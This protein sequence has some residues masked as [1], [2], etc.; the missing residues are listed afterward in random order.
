V[1]IDLDFIVRQSL[2]V[3]DIILEETGKRIDSVGH[4]D[5]REILGR[6]V[7]SNLDMLD[8]L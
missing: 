4:G 2:D 5:D 6:V 8:E 7:A 3:N 1:E